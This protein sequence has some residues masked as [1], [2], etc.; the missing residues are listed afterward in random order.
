MKTFILIILLAVI[1]TPASIAQQRSISGHATYISTGAE[2]IE[3]VEGRTLGKTS[4][5]AVLFEDDPQSPL[6]LMSQDCSGTNLIGSNGTLIQSVGSCFAVDSDGDIFWISFVN[7]PEGGTW[8]YTAGT[9]KFAGIEGGGTSEVIA[10]GHDGQLTI[11]YEGQ[12]IMR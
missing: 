5:S 6:H 8:R 4:S 12:I 9:G 1:A 2:S 3:L 11:R 10:I 7:P